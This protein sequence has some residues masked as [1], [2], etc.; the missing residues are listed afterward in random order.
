MQTYFL[1]LNFIRVSI[2]F[3]ANCSFLIKFT[4]DCSGDLMALEKMAIDSTSRGRVRF[5]NRGQ[6]YYEFR[7]SFHRTIQFHCDVVELSHLNVYFS[8]SCEKWFRIVF[9]YLLQ[10]GATMLSLV[11]KCCIC[12]LPDWSSAL[13]MQSIRLSCCKSVFTGNNCADQLKFNESDWMKFYSF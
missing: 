2:G 3:L 10:N 11:S 9:F 13:F 4:T 6:W 7:A 8:S 12:T 1:G 5:Y